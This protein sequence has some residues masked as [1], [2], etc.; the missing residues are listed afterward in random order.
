MKKLY[1]IILL[2][3][4]ALFISC[5]EKKAEDDIKK[6]FTKIT[7]EAADV[8]DAV[9]KIT[10]KPKGSGTLTNTGGEEAG[11][12]EAEG[13]TETET[14]DD[15]PPPALTKPVLSATRVEVRTAVI[16]PKVPGYTYA[17]K[18][19][20]GDAVPSD[21][22]LSDVMSDTTKKKVS[23]TIAISGIIV[24]ATKDG[25]SIDSEGIE[26]TLP[27]PTPSSSITPPALSSYHVEVGTAVT[28]PKVAGHT[29]SLEPVISGVTL[30]VSDKNMGRITA[31][32][33]AIGVI[34]IAQTDEGFV[35]SKPINFIEVIQPD[36]TLTVVPWD[37][38]IE[39]PKVPRHTYKLKEAVN[40]VSLDVSDENT[41]RITATQSAQNVIIVATTEGLSVESY[42]IEFKRIPGNTLSFRYSNQEKRRSSGI[43]QA[44]TK[45]G[46]VTGD[47]GDDRK[48]RYAVSPTSNGVTINANT[49]AI[50]IGRDATY[51]SYTVTAELPEDE[52]YT[53]ATAIYTLVVK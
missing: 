10:P 9:D 31:T 50:E 17:L 38:P 32:Q 37:T 36:I 15:T 4:L 11:D 34:V 43:L 27:P 45:S 44:A 7:D 8:V 24:V 46:A 22:T 51:G 33:E 18:L 47:D 26:F 25:K 39:F 28:F 41:G 30:N 6:A 40:G 12:E 13:E 16:F 29:Y 23:S 3:T 20:S 52:K 42:P 53:R 21:V 19:F 1:K 5:D 49:G 2:I 48:I 35:R 14:G